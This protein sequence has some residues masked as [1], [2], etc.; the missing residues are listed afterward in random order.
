MN[1]ASLPYSWNARIARWKD[2]FWIDWSP[3][4][5][6]VGYNGAEEFRFELNRFRTDDNN[7]PIYHIHQ[8][9]LEYD[10]TVI[11]LARRAMANA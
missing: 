9:P 2:S 10:K 1:L 11:G 4:G 7:R 8:A 5:V 3:P 6:W